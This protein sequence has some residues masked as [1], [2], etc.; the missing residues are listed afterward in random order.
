[1]NTLRVWATFLF[2]AAWALSAAIRAEPDP[3]RGKTDLSAWN[4]EFKLSD[5]K[6]TN[7]ETMWALVF[8]SNRAKVATFFGYDGK[9]LCNYLNGEDGKKIAGWDLRF[10]ATAVENK[11]KNTFEAKSLISSIDDVPLVSTVTTKCQQLVDVHG[12]GSQSYPWLIVT[13]R[14]VPGKKS[15][16]AL[17]TDDARVV[18]ELATGWVDLGSRSAGKWTK[19]HFEWPEAQATPQEGDW[20]QATH[21]NHLYADYLR[22]RKESDIWVGG[23]IVTAIKSGD[24][25]FVDAVKE[26]GEGSVW[27]KIGPSVAPQ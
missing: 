1:M 2:M 10:A 25:F 26:L 16:F 20:I 11:E 22:H 6:K 7:S 5:V 24:Q 3:I 9:G 21:R 18:R 19:K 4:G 15:D 12:M 17:W 8:P 23:P 13:N 27:A 14:F